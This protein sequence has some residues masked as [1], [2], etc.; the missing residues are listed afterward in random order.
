MGLSLSMHRDLLYAPAQ[1]EMNS[2]MCCLKAKISMWWSM[3]QGGR[4]CVQSTDQG[5]AGCFSWGIS[6][7]SGRRRFPL[8]S[9]RW[10]ALQVTPCPSWPLQRNRNCPGRQGHIA[11]FAFPFGRSLLPAANGSWIL[12]RPGFSVSLTV[13]GD[14]LLPCER[15]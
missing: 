3:L 7:P 9:G 15:C 10:R 5:L 1:S 11:L 8:P 2:E 4:R 12:F 13:V 6:I 14:P